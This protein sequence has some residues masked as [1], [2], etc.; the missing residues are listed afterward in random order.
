M[1]HYTN[2]LW[3]KDRRQLFKELYHQYI[4]EGYSQKEAK[5][6]ARE[7]SMDIYADSVDFA[8]DAADMEFDQ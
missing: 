5:R 4:E 1:S 2:N 7:D 3:E 6:L 8:M